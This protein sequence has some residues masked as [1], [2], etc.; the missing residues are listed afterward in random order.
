[1]TPPASTA[2][3]EQRVPPGHIL[4]Y[5][6]R[7]RLVHWL[8][9]LSYIYLLLTGLAFWSPWLFWIA[10]ILGGAPV[11]R[12]LH[13]WIGLL[14][15]VG[16]VQMF[17]LWASHM[18]FTE[19]DRAWLRSMSH[20][21]SNEDENMP[22]AG[23]YNAGQKLLFWGF[24]LCGLLLLLSGLV[25]WFPEYIPWSLRYLRYTAV[26]VHASAAL[27]TIGLFMLHVY[28]GVFAERGALDSVIHGDVT[29]D[30]VRRFHPG[31][32]KEIVGSSTPRK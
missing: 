17:G 16:I 12:M 20:Y 32:Y 11:S 28:M 5:T 19:V 14:F 3:A 31:W 29:E 7:E 27:I 15:F 18:G 26:I 13:P 23:R 8:A 10:V 4:R 6:F 22:P 30:F 2:H 21:I 24:V 25:L 9:A 1:V